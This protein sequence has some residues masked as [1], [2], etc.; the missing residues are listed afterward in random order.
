MFKFKNIAKLR[1]INWEVAPQSILQILEEVSL[2]FILKVTSNLE[3]RS[4][5]RKTEDRCKVKEIKH[6]PNLL[7]QG[8]FDSNRITK[9]VLGKS[10][11]GKIEKVLT[12][13]IRV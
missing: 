6:L 5:E 1:L 4:L 11:D 2:S 7:L 12:G 9:L 13:S 3:L 8:Y 10:I